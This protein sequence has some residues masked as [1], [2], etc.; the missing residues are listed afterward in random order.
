MEKEKFYIPDVSEGSTKETHSNSSDTVT[1][2]LERYND[3]IAL[4]A[5]TTIL[6]RSY[7]A[8]KYSSDVMSVIK[9]LFGPKPTESDND[10]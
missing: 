3:L 10:A 5:K 1:I 2:P 7:M 4:E 6:V 8:S 9:L